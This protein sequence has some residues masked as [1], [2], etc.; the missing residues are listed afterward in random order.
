MNNQNWDFQSQHRGHFL[1]VSFFFFFCI[2][3]ALGLSVIWMYNHGFFFEISFE[4]TAFLVTD[5]IKIKNSPSRWTYWISL[6]LLDLSLQHVTLPVC[7]VQLGSVVCVA[8]DKMLSTYWNALIG[9]R[10]IVCVVGF[11][12]WLKMHYSTA[13]KWLGAFRHLMGNQF[14]WERRCLW[15]CTSSEAVHGSV[16]P[17][18]GIS[19][20]QQY[21]YWVGV[22]SKH[23]HQKVWSVY[24]KPGKNP[25][26]VR[27]LHFC[28]HWVMSSPA[29][30]FTSQGAT[31][32]NKAK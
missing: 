11:S 15:S 1:K 12:F 17:Y 30:L 28:E 29:S 24:T 7:V 16:S 31:N 19:Q 22:V 20:T 2:F 32:V 25:S 8:L 18:R 13:P 21:W 4:K 3:K 23:E 27:A 10:C 26:H 6:M 5:E 14:L 9:Y